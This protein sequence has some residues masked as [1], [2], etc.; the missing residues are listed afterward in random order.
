MHAL[1]LHLSIPAKTWLIFY[2]L[3]TPPPLLLKSKALQDVKELLENGLLAESEVIEI[4]KAVP[5]ADVDADLVNFDGF[6]QAF[7]RIDAL[8]EDEEE[9]VKREGVGSVDGGVQAL[10]GGNTVVASFEELAGS[11]EGLLDL[12]GLLR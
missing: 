9:E 12:A 4:W 8:F 1:A 11:S 2:F 6:S 10:G 3:S 5:K 7:A